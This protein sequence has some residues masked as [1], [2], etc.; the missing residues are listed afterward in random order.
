MIILNFSLIIIQY[1]NV[2]TL[3]GK[4][5]DTKIQFSKEFTNASLRSYNK[6][7]KCGK[8]AGQYSFS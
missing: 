3:P 8:Y 7:M 2:Q 4:N 1:F 6:N 5:D